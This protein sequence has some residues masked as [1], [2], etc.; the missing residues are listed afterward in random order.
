MTT[1]ITVYDCAACDPIEMLRAQVVTLREAL[2]DLLDEQNGPPL[3][4]RE[5]Q[6]TRAHD[7]AETLFDVTEP[8]GGA[9]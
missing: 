9:K 2:R 8:K 6:W 7:N 4:Q 5:A 3:Y 1:K